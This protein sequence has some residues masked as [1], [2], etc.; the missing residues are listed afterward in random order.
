MAVT[1]FA[2][3]IKLVG[4]YNNGQEQTDTLTDAFID[5][6]I[7]RATGECLVKFDQWWSTHKNEYPV[8]QQVKV[9]VNIG[10]TSSVP[11]CIVYNANRP[12]TV[13][14]FNGHVEIDSNENAVTFSGFDFLEAVSVKEGQLVV[15]L[16]ITPCF[17]KSK[18][19]FKVGAGSKILL[20]HEQGHF[21]ITAINACEL[22]EQLRHTTFTKDNYKTLIDELG[23]EYEQ[24]K[25]DEQNAYDSET[26]HSKIM[27]K[28]LEWQHKISEQ[29]KGLECYQ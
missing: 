14:D 28:Q 8:S 23:K 18:S 24:K 11:E 15:N 2:G 1:F 27:D 19:W 6:F 13:G 12:L 10:K 20:A 21:D 4:Y 7:R 29:L 25:N 5:E 26:N 16:T 9:N 17:N 22:V 3:G